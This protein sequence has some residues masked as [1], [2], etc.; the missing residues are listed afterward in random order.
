[1]NIAQ[2]AIDKKVITIVITLLLFFGGIKSY[3]KLGRLEDP[4]F[5]VKTARVIT[6]YPGA[7]AME[8]S[9]EVT[10]K[11]EIA[12]QKLGQLKYITSLSMPGFSSIEVEIEDKYTADDLPQVWDELRRK[13]NDV[14]DDLPPGTSTS[15]VWDDFGDVYGIFFAIY[16]DGYTDKEIYEYSK[17]LR[18]ELLL[19]QDVADITLFGVRQERVYVEIPR[20]RIAQ[21]GISPKLIYASLAGQNMVSDAGNIEVGSQYVRI[22]PTGELTS[23]EDI[24]NVSLLAADGET[25]LFLRDIATIRRGYVDPPGVILRFNGMRSVGLGIST[26]AGGNVV[27]MGQAVSQ[28]LKELQAE[29]PIGMEI[30]IVSHQGDSVTDSIGSFVVNLVE[31][32]IIVV[33]VLVF[34]MGFRSGILIGGVLLLTI[35]A[36]FVMMSIKNVMLERISLGALIIALGMLVDNAIVIADG[37]LIGAQKGMS[38]KDAAV[39]IVQQTMWPL[40]GATCVAILAFA[41]IGTSKDSTG[42]YCRS[43][44]QVLLYSLMLSWVL[45]ITVTPLAAS[46]FLKVKK[47]EGDE[48]P[49]GGV[50]YQSY[51]KLLVACMRRRYLVI[52]ILVGFLAL[53]VYGFGFVKKSFFPDSTRPQFM[54]HFWMPQGTHIK[55]TEKHVEIFEKW[56]HQQEGVTD[57]SSIIGQGA[58]RFLLT[59]TPEESN[60]AY[61]L[62]LVSV[63]DYRLVDDLMAKCDIFLKENCPEAQAFCRRFML[64]PGEANKIQVRLR[65]SD[66]DV[67]RDLSDKVQQIMRDEPSAVD[68]N[69]DWCQRVPLLRPIVSD[70]AARNAG[71]TRKDIARALQTVTDGTAVGYY[72]ERDELIPIM[73]RNPESERADARELANIQIYSP[74]ARGFIPIQQVVTDFK[75]VSENQ[76]IRR[77]NRQ[78]TLTV[79]CDPHTGKQATLVFDKLRPK[80]EAIILPE[81]YSLVWGGEYEDSND[82]ISGLQKMLPII[83][84]FMVLVVIILFNS[85]K[86]PL[87]IFATVP[88]ALIGVT[89][90]LLL[91]GQPFGFMALLGFLSLTGMLIKNSVVLV[92][93]INAQLATGK[94][95]F[96]AIADSGVSRI[97]PVTLAAATTVLGM[98]PLL[99]DAFFVAMAVTIM[100]GLAFATLLTLFVIPVLYTAIFRI[101]ETKV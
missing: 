77:R 90:G 87:V 7:T 53:S 1:M 8:V 100:F 55:K 52:V 80:V 27:T 11:V 98:I 45:A 78:P 33:V 85:V 26:A 18:R 29:T 5:T 30:G 72:R 4:E 46:S 66:P 24:G 56:V 83:F 49:Y 6:Y 81:G 73:Y 96:Q 92:D 54:V 84:L 2:V 60:S 28:R 12:I 76:I 3:N 48:D 10:D 47:L 69:T 74:I 25:K 70:T 94:D 51:R 19:V 93:E 36:T 50:F 23:I 75:M 22:F 59:Y 31:A 40:F 62:V 39:D 71:L 61:G 57:I 79:R 34:A 101:K 9:D 32:I 13:V 21:L 42:E 58:I 38:K 43:L 91:M 63:E 15:L 82:A 88:L 97:R 68:I 44:Y 89:I 41:A 99:K 16:G 14:Q 64:G 20:E 35:L 37:I 67:L 17:L 95:P 65:G 86:Q